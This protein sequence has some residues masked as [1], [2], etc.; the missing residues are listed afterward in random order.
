MPE[1]SS[2]AFWHL[3]HWVTLVHHI[4]ESMLEQALYPIWGSV[5]L[6]QKV[7]NKEDSR[8]YCQTIYSTLFILQRTRERTEFA[9][10]HRPNSGQ[11]ETSSSFLPWLDLSSLDP[12]VLN[13]SHGTSC[14]FNFSFLLFC[15]SLC[16]L[17]FLLVS[18]LFFLIIFDNSV[19]QTS[20]ILCWWRTRA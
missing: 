7:T 8:N 4:T 17:S 3:F 11:K 2:S 20:S 1:G 12:G 18:Y 6:N 5:V 19:S 14:T 15:S 9:H 10:C 13:W 16:L